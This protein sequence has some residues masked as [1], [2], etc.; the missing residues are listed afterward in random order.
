[1]NTTSLYKS[2]RCTLHTVHYTLKTK[3][4][5]KRQGKAQY[6]LANCAA[7][8]NERAQVGDLR[9][10]KFRHNSNICRRRA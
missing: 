8:G 6:H 7:L 1:M 4:T 9:W 3:K 5:I 2:T 10:G